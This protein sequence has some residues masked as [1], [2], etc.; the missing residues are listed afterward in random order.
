M[1]SS[2]LLL[3]TRV[4]ES[5][6]SVRGLAACALALGLPDRVPYAGI[7]RMIATSSLELDPTIA[8]REPAERLLET[9][10]ADAVSRATRSARKVAVLLS[11]GLDSS[12]VLGAL[13]EQKLASDVIPITWDLGASG[14]DEPYI[15]AWEARLGRRVER[16][17]G[18]MAAPLL[19]DSFVLGASPTALM[20]G[21]FERAAMRRAKELGAQ[22]LLTGVGGDEIFSGSLQAA[23]RSD[24]SWS[25]TLQRAALAELPWGSTARQRVAELVWRP[26]LRSFVPTRLREMMFVTRA[27]R[28]LPGLGS[29]GLGQLREAARVHVSAL[30][31][32]PRTAAE[33]HRELVGRPFW[34]EMGE[35]R[36]QLESSEQLPRFDIPL[37][38]GVARA[39]ATIAPHLLFD[40]SRHRGLLRRVLQRQAPQVVVARFDKGDFDDFAV[41][42]LQ[43]SE[44]WPRLRALAKSPWLARLDIVRPGAVEALW[45]H[46]D[47]M[48]G[49]LSTLLVLWPFLSAEAF[50]ETLA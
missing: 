5:R 16:V 22:V 11:G 12:A 32:V 29:V 15:R 50:A 18:A 31:P 27:R 36:A 10:I 25:H 35:L 28:E 39:V 19:R 23:V 7:E 34:L 37:D 24:A 9:T 47:E 6:L 42:L 44:I 20:T 21:A 48:P 40:E 45:S 26:G 49:G 17:G 3:L 14:G 41:K 13:H 46:A 1:A 38:A 8:E 43:A 2:S 4:L 33:R 30:R